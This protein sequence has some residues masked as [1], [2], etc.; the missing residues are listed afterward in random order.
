MNLRTL[1]ATVSTIRYT[2]ALSYVLLDLIA[3]LDTHTTKTES[4]YA[5]NALKINIAQKEQ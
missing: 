5:M 3:I 1:T 2:I 4:M